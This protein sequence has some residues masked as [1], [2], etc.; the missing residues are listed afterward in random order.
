MLAQDYIRLVKRKYSK[1]SL[2]KFYDEICVYVHKGVPFQ[3]V[4]RINDYLVMH[5]NKVFK[6]H[7][8]GEQVGKYIFIYDP[9]QIKIKDDLANARD[10]ILLVFD[11]HT[12]NIQVIPLEESVWKASQAM[13][14]K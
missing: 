5:H 2:L 1:L 4:F 9:V 14:N 6:E 12:Q 11:M 8:Q 3:C 10:N 7:G 13:A